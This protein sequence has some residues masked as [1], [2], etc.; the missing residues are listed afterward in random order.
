M[1]VDART[2]THGSTLDADVC[3]IGA[4]AAGIAL[5]REFAGG[6][7]RV[8]V[9]ESGGFRPGRAAQEFL[10][11]EAF[12]QPVWPLDESRVAAF[13]GTTT[14]WSGACRP[15]DDSDFHAREWVPDS[16]WPIDRSELDPFYSRAH[17]VCQLGPY[18]YAL[19]NWRR[20][21]CTPLPVSDEH[22][23]T[24][25]FQVSPPTRFGVVYRRE[26][27]AASNV[28]VLLHAPV[29]EIDTT[30]NGQCVSRVE[31][32]TAGHKHLAVTARVVV[33]AAGGIENARM[34]LLSNKVRPAGLGNDH[35]Q[36]GR[37]FQDHLF[38]NGGTLTLQHAD[39]LGFYGRHTTLCGP[40]PATIEPVLSVAEERLARE[41]LLRCA[42]LVPPEWRIMPEFSS[43]GV[44]SVRHLLRI[45]R[46][47]G[48]PPNTARHLRS[49]TVDAYKIARV[50]SVAMRSRRQPRRARYG[51]RSM[52]EQ[53]PNPNSRIT[54]SRQ[55]DAL[56]RQGVH[57]DWQLTE[58]DFRTVRRGHEIL[59][60]AI[61]K[62]G[63]GTFSTGIDAE[64]A[65]RSRVTSGY[66]HMG[67]TRMNAD[68][69]HGVVDANARV[70]G[71][72]NLYV[73]GSSIFPTT[74]YVNPTL[75][76]V[77][78]TLRLADHLRARLA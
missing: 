3:I 5:A 44:S 61:C 29:V 75:T 62:A 32:V 28:Q 76:I 48:V 10:R 27:D 43:R 72:S 23:E 54:L 19:D 17:E 37:Y 78:L 65:W 55:R 35:D 18:T 71:T 73:A 7:T 1:I 15:L 24:H 77:A 52:S 34:L 26:L 12:G 25:V 51:T 36:V 46:L 20:A 63:L 58:L 70:H 8:C 53:S 13:G 47:G 30:Q 56:G 45:L 50:V 11:A 57:L 69:R 16:G 42:F 41:G 40:S 49:M 33:L 6:S 66:H 31:F 14:I 22:L 68:P 74:G 2:L 9:L 67:T 39:L 59:G 38:L 4:G 60:E 64:G 21:D